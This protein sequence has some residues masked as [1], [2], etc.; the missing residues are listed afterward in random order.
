MA[1]KK[2]TLKRFEAVALPKETALRV[3]GGYR[4]SHIPTLIDPGTKFIGWGEIEIRTGQFDRMAETGQMTLT[5]RLG[6]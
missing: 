5:P 4:N 1:K 6:R 2:D 3:K